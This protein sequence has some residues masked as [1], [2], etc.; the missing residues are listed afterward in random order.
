MLTLSA[1]I[2]RIV[3]DMNVILKLSSKIKAIPPSFVIN[4]NQISLD[5]RK[6]NSFFLIFNQT[7][8]AWIEK[9]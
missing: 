9:K 8:N 7:K 4:Y 3:D 1:L 2:N 5:E 6:K